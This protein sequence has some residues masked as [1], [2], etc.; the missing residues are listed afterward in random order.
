[1]RRTVVN[2]PTTQATT[3][4]LGAWVLLGTIAA[5][6]SA[7]LTGVLLASPDT[8]AGILML[9]LS[10]PWLAASW[11]LLSG[12]LSVAIRRQ[13]QAPRAQRSRRAMTLPVRA[14]ATASHWLW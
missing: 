7:M 14:L 5:T 11:A 8:A 6:W 1:M 3:P 2:E 9:A 12:P 4:M 10:L 13:A